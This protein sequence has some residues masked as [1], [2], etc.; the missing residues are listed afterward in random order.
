MANKE[1]FLSLVTDADTSVIADAKNREK[2]RAMLEESQKI[3]LKVLMRLDELNWSQKDLAQKMEVSPQQVNKI[4]S[5]TQNL[6]IETQVKLQTLLNIPILASYYEQ[7]NQA[8]QNIGVKFNMVQT[9]EPSNSYNT[10][11]N[12][13]KIVAIKRKLGMPNQTGFTYSIAQ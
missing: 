13:C 5:G 2:N 3:A 9:I 10:Y 8:Q 1:K 6:T 11:Q 4:L 12:T 7:K